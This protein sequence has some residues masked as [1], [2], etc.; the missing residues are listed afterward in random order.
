MTGKIPPEKKKKRGEK[1]LLG[2]KMKVIV[3][4]GCADSA[5]HIC[6]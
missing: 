1:K 5:K 2:R 3:D 4:G 6:K